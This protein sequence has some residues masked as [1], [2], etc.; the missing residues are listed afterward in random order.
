MLGL[1]KNKNKHVL[2]ASDSDVIFAD[3]QNQ[4]G[5]HYSINLLATQKRDEKQRM[6]A[7]EMVSGTGRKKAKVSLVLPLSEFEIVSVSVPP[8]GREAISKM[9][10]YSLS[11]I[12]DKP[13]SDYIYDWQ[14]AQSFKDRHEL[15]VFL[16]SA[17]RYEEYRRDLL[18]HQ[19]EIAWFEPDV[20]AACSYLDG[21]L[22]EYADSTILC[23]LIYQHYVSLAIYEKQRITVLRSVE[24]ELPE[25]LPQEDLVETSDDIAFISDL[26]DVQKEIVVEEHEDEAGEI[27]FT[28]V[29][30]IDDV[31]SSESSYRAE[32]GSEDILSGFGLQGVEEYTI[33]EEQTPATIESDFETEVETVEDNLWE[34]YIEDLNLEIMRTGDYH[35]SVLKGKAVQKIFLG[36]N[37]DIYDVLAQWVRKNNSIT[38]DRFPPENIE[39]ECSQALAAISIGALR[40]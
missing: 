17:A 25:G 6:S 24:M 32:P 1:L 34:E 31:N 28:L 27:E 39:A 33:V 9:L 2:A 20:F 7:G 10:P 3:V 40:R 38:I 37:D 19:K 21:Q 18:A 35:T 5:G 30:E 22:Q 16:Y 29:S 4:K 36:T 15:T 12:L 8:V 14:V 26:N 23:V 13:V 11:K